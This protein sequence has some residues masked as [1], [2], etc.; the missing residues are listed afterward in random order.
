MKKIAGRALTTATGGTVTL[1][2]SWSKATLV[3]GIT[4]VPTSGPRPAAILS[5]QLV[6]ERYGRSGYLDIEKGELIYAI[7]PSRHMCPTVGGLS[8]E[9][10]KLC[11]SYN[12]V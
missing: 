2:A 1:L 11:E 8:M 7:V 6:S 12:I 10:Q 9:L 5:V 4:S 3:P